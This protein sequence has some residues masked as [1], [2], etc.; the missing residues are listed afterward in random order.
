MRSIFVPAREANDLTLDKDVMMRAPRLE[1]NLMRS[2]E[3]LLTTRHH[4]YL[5]FNEKPTLS[6]SSVR[7]ALCSG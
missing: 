1:S 7:Q 5:D 3:A 4:G 2:G 6:V